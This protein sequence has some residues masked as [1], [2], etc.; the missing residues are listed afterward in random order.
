MSY[1][2]IAK[3]TKGYKIKW[4][5][6]IFPEY[7]NLSGPEVSQKRINRAKSIV[8]LILEQEENKIT[9]AFNTFAKKKILQSKC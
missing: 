3:S 6:G 7:G 8:K 5:K 2:A 1:K 4:G 9:K